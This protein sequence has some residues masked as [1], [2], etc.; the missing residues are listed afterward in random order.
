[1]LET[2]ELSLVRARGLEPRSTESK[3]VILPLDYARL[4]G[5]PR[6]NR[7]PVVGLQNQSST[8]ELE[9]H[10]SG[11]GESNSYQKLGRLVSCQWT[12][13]AES[14]LGRLRRIELPPHGSQPCALTVELQPPFV[15]RLDIGPSTKNRTSVC[16]LSAGCSPV[17]L[18]RGSEVRVGAIGKDDT[19]TLFILSARISET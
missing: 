14:S 16:R 17:E 11:S 13:P 3:T 6:G 5:A 7:T 2:H 10:W 8:I 15:P 9:G 4:N 19:D 1:M 18:S 12:R